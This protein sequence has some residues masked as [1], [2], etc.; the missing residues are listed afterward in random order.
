M[1]ELHRFV[2]YAV[3]AGFG[4]LVVMSL[5]GYFSNKEPGGWYWNTL[6]V[7][8]VVLGIQ[9]IVGAVLFISGATPDSNGPTWLHYVYGA[10]FP[11]LVLLVA[12]RQARKRPGAEMIFFGVA[13][14][15][16]TFSTL[17]ALQTGL[18]ID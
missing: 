5:F 17:R 10:G 16:C 14:F 18:G 13:A 3:P 6:A 15:L 2:A 8:Q 4:V 9:F 1:T 11:L 12:H 7:L